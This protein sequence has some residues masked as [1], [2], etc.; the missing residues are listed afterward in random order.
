MKNGEIATI[1]RYVGGAAIIFSILLLI[2]IAII[3]STSFNYSLYVDSLVVYLILLL[4]GFS[5]MSVGFY[6][7][8]S[9]LTE[10][11]GKTFTVDEDLGKSYTGNY[12]GIVYID[13]IRVGIRSGK[14][15]ETGDKVRIIDYSV[16]V[17]LG[18]RLC[19]LLV[20]TAEK[21]EITGTEDDF[22]KP[23]N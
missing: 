15:L 4:S 6:L 21:G 7:R 10:A 19:P 2:F 1:L 13:G 23:V 14:P 5:L 11:I 20:E 22:I 16:S 8:K 9:V 12:H 17:S 18:D 3:L